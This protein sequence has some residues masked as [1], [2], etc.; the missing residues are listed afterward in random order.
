MLYDILST[1][2]AGFGLWALGFRWACP[3]KLR[4]CWSLGFRWACPGKLRA[5]WSLGFRWACPGKLRACNKK[6]IVN[7]LCENWVNTDCLPTPDIQPLLCSS[8]FCSYQSF[9]PFFNYRDNM[10]IMRSL[11][12]VACCFVAYEQKIY[13]KCLPI[14]HGLP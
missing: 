8:L 13:I 3:G 9:Y 7:L 14:A 12:I 11:K 10:S 6:S 2:M 4:A 5:C 1:H